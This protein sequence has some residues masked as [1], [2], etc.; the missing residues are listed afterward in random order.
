MSRPRM[1]LKDFHAQMRPLD[2]AFLV[3]YSEKYKMPRQEILRRIIQ[4]FVDKDRDLDVKDLGK[5]ATSKVLAELED[6]ELREELKRQL[7]AFTED[8]GKADVS[9][10]TVP[11]RK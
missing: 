8:R 5:V 6:P 9:T 10:R 4:T 3:Y 11:A 7:K 2:Y 1:F